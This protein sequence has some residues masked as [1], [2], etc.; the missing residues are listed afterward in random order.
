MLQFA[1]TLEGQDLADFMA[2]MVC[3][4][5]TDDTFGDGVQG[6]SMSAEARKRQNTIGRSGQHVKRRKTSGSNVRR[7]EKRKETKSH[8]VLEDDEGAQPM[9]RRSTR[10]GIQELPSK[11]STALSEQCKKKI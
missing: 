4:S 9:R 2:L 7:K 10:K 1:A 6:C 8:F 11:R 3:T 5:R